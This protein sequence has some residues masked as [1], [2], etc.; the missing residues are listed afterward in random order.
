MSLVSQEEVVTLHNLEYL[1]ECQ[2]LANNLDTVNQQPETYCIQ[3]LS[4]VLFCFFSLED[5]GS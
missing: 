1:H 4:I 5:A 2:Q 3:E